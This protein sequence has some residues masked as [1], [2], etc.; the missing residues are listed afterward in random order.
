MWY[1][2]CMAIIITAKKKKKEE[3]LY[4]VLLFLCYLHACSK[5]KSNKFVI[6]MSLFIFFFLS[7]FLFILFQLNSIEDYHCLF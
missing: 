4:F 5:M 2:L 7:R 3:F 6:W 1:F